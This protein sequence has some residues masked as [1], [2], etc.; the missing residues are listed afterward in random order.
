MNKCAVLSFRVACSAFL[1]AA[2]V[3]C[4][5]TPAQVY[6]PEE[7][8]RMKQEREA[9]AA[10][11]KKERGERLR[12]EAQALSLFQLS[13]AE[14]IRSVEQFS[15]GWRGRSRCARVVD[16]GYPGSGWLV[17]RCDDGQL[18]AIET[19]KGDALPVSCFFAAT[20]FGISC[21]EPVWLLGKEAR[22]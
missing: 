2:L 12:K 4:A 11:E 14:K 15:A 8:A 3:S 6:S 10:I 16:L 9:R 18:F 22:D 5:S 7:Q 21:D 13:D 1:L 17:A 19:G 20:Y